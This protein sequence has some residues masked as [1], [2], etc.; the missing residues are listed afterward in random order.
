MWAP[1]RELDGACGGLQGQDTSWADLGWELSVRVQAHGVV[2]RCAR[3][4]SRMMAE[5]GLH[6][7]GFHSVPAALLPFLP[8]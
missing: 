6:R 1:V 5:P 4:W 8:P 7:Q 3:V 2:S